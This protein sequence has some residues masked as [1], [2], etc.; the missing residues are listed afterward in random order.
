MA[1]EGEAA[2]TV[3]VVLWK[4]EGTVEVQVLSAGTTADR[5]RPVERTETC[6]VQRAAIDVAGPNK[7]KRCIKEP[8]IPAL[9]TTTSL[10]SIVESI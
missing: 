4:D 9:V 2:P 8:S 7:I 1:A 3:V 5:T 10:T 6:D